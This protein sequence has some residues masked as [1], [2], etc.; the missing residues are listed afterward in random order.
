MGWSN[1]MNFWCV[2][3]RLGAT[4]GCTSVHP[5]PPTDQAR[6]T[7]HH[8]TFDVVPPVM[9]K[10]SAIFIAGCAP[11]AHRDLLMMGLEGM[12]F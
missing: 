7:H 2:L 5:G 6:S 8:S 9:E 11:Q 12:F 4:I 3:P 10:C 1:L